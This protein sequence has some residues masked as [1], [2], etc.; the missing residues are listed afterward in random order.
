MKN[1]DATL[2]AILD[3]EHNHRHEVGGK[4]DTEHDEQRDCD[5]ACSL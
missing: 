5:V 3:S 2:R 4:S 1:S